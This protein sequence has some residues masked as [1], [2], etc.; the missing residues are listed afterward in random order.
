MQGDIDGPLLGE[1]L[2]VLD[3]RL[4]LNGVV[5]GHAVTLDHVKRGAVKIPRHV[6]PRFVVDVADVDH[7]RVA[8]P[9]AAGIAHPG[10]VVGGTVGR[11][12]GV[13]HAVLELSHSKAMVTALGF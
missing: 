11:A 4:V 7:Q 6:Q 13:N 3:G 2:P 5:I 9:M 8:F 10:I 1:Y 12:V